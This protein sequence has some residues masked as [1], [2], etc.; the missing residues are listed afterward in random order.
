LSSSVN[1]FR[2][3]V[4]EKALE[5]G[6]VKN[7][8]W[9]G[10]PSLFID[11]ETAIEERIEKRREL[12]RRAQERERELAYGGSMY[13]EQS[14]A[15]VEEIAE[16]EWRF[17]DPEQYYRFGK[18]R[19]RRREMLEVQK[20]RSETMMRIS[21]EAEVSV[22]EYMGVM[23]DFGLCSPGNNTSLLTADVGGWPFLPRWS[24]ARLSC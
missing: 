3:Y 22:D 17:Y 14:W 19:E 4:Y 15:E 13:D 5:A 12:K 24:M 10:I 2:Q 9:K 16:D 20:T 18:L 1:S 21:A 11:R 7:T 23:I 6:D 8:P